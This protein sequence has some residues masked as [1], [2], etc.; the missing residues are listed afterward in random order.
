MFH[1]HATCACWRLNLCKFV[2]LFFSPIFS[3]LSL[4]LCVFH[5]TVKNS[6]EL[7][8]VARAAQ[9][10]GD[11]SQCLFK[12]EQ[13][14][15]KH[16]GVSERLPCVVTVLRRRQTGEF[17]RS[18]RNHNK[19]FDWG[20]AQIRRSRSPGSVVPPARLL[21]CIRCTGECTPQ[22]V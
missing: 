4:C 3:S 19:V 10:R 18:N 11:A 12:P 5:S 6:K 9:C 8:S 22:I 15:L 21:G 7:R 13:E 20:G 16:A 14:T 1:A 2:R 17:R